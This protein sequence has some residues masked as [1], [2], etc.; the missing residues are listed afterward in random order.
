MG[1]HVVPE[2]RALEIDTPLDF[3][4]AEVHMRARHRQ[5]FR[6]LLPATPGALVMDFDGV[7]SDNAVYV[8]QN[9]VEAVRCDRGDGLGLSTLKKTGL[10][11]LILSKEQN[12]VVT[13]R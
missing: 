2:D 5:G 7:L 1:V 6:P 10:P 9:G 13:R 4:T 11:L 8:D 3:A 12:P